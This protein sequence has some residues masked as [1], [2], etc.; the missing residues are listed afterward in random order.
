M[1]TAELLQQQQYQGIRKQ[2]GKAAFKQHYFLKYSHRKKSTYNGKNHGNVVEC[3][4]KYRTDFEREKHRQLR[5]FV[6]L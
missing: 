5:M 3:V 2:F 4:R 1:I 6:I